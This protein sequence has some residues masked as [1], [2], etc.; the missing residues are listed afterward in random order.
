[1]KKIIIKNL[2][3]VY[4]CYEKKPGFK[5]SIKGLFK[6]DMVTKVANNNIS[7]EINEGEFVGL[8]GPNG[9]GKTTLIKMMCGIIQPTNGELEILGFDPGNMTNEFKKQIALVMGQKSQLWWDLPAYDSLMLNKTIYELSDEEF[10]EKI[11]KFS[12]MFGIK[13]LLNIQVRQLS[14]G[15]R[16]KME[17][18]SC[19]LH[20][21]KVIFLDEPTIGL[22]AIAQKNIRQFLTDI[23]KRL[24]T[25]IILTSHY[26]EDIRYLCSRVI[27]INHGQKVYDGGLEQLLNEFCDTKTVTIV[28]EQEFDVNIE[29]EIEWLIREPYRI[30]F[31]IK[32]NKLNAMLGKLMGSYGISDIKIEEEDIS[33][34][35]EKIYSA[36]VGL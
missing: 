36:E 17:L 23:N 16:M 22:D 3:K 19:L 26:M 28:L 12:E 10:E 18:I 11:N 14:L 34:V 1:M 6:R 32:K 31:K 4:E 27:V 9:A 35:I 33:D 21:P 2:S 25:T 20:N 29:E 15:E 24:G 7:L 30:S 8:I 5:N 13:D